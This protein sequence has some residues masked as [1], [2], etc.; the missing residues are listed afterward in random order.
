MSWEEVFKYLICIGFLWNYTHWV[1]HGES[2]FH[3]SPSMSDQDH[4]NEVALNDVE[5]LLNDMVRSVQSEAGSEEP[6]VEASKFYK[7]V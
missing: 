2:T 1:M 7:L 5:D 3:A 6:N 4:E